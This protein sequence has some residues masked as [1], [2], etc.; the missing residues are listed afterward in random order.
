MLGL[1]G[2][3]K[4]RCAWIQ[5]LFAAV[6]SQQGVKKKVWIQREILLFFAKSPEC[7][8]LQTSDAF[9][10]EKLQFLG[11]ERLKIDSCGALIFHSLSWFSV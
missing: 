11:S 1:P 4:E 5:S 3:E 9:A 7:E 2:K 8:Q 6:G 10:K